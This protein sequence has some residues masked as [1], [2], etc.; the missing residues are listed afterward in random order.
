MAEQTRKKVLFLITK[1]NWGGAQR[2]VYDLATTLDKTQFEAVVALGGNGIL[3]EMLQHAGIRT[4]PIKSLV[5]DVSVKNEIEFAKELWQILGIEKPDIFHVNSSKAGAIG[6]LLGRLRFVPRVIF[7][8]HGWAFNEDRAWWQKTIIKTIHWFTVICSHRTIA[9]SSAIV[10]Q[11]Q[12]PF[13]SAKMKIINP[14]RTIGAMYGKAEARAALAKFY[15]PLE[16][17]QSDRWI[18]SIAELHPIKRL[19][20]LLES[21]KTIATRIRFII[22]GEGQ[23]RVELEKFIET[24]HLQDNV[25]LTGSITEAARFLKAADVFVLPSKSESYGYV[26]HE[27]GLAGVPIVATRVGGITDIISSETEG[28][29]IPPDDAVA[30]TTALTQALN[31]KQGALERAEKLKEKLQSRSVQTMTNATTALYLLPLK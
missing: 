12:W 21:A 19:L 9:V 28:I 26:V 4:I 24:N 5:R 20:V 1:S 8:A 18:I 15:P 11:L 22:I 25:F 10:T 23:Q 6:T 29:L 17:F 16:S 13:T 27:A 7:T 31:E 14:G 2:Y 3:F 30:L